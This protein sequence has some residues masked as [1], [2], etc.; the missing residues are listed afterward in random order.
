M[1]TVYDYAW[2][3]WLAAFVIIEGISLYR[4]DYPGTLTAHV[5]H[6][7]GLDG[8]TWFWRFRRA[9]LIGFMGWLSLHF[10]MPAG[11]F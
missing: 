4:D 8:H 11:S 7:F 2:F 6:W 9:V 1:H 10:L 5:R 3:L